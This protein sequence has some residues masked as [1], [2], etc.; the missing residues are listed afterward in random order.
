MDQNENQNRSVVKVR[1][2]GKEIKEGRYA[3]FL[4]KIRV[5][6]NFLKLVMPRNVLPK[7]IEICMD[8]FC[9]SLP[10]WE[11]TLPPETK[12]NICHC[13]LLKSVSLSLEEL[14]NIKI[15]IFLIHELFRSIAKFPELS[16]FFNQHDSSFGRHVNAA[17]RKSVDIQPRTHSGRTFSTDISFQLL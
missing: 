11:P 8:T 10:G 13:V 14:R 1:N 7:F 4:A 12:R 16:H 5:I 3:K 6:A 9:R 15:I 2:L 17:S